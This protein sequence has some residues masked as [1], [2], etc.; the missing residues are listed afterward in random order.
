MPGLRGWIGEIDVE[1]LLSHADGRTRAL[2]EF[3][4]AGD[5]WKAV[6][7]H[8]G[9]ARGENARG[10]FRYGIRKAWERML[11]RGGRPPEHDGD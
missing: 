2:Y 1:V 9:I 3:W 11:S 8:L 10:L 5:S 4:S 7:R 6:A